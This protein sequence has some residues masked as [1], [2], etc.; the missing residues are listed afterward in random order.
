MQ[1]KSLTVYLGSGGKA[2][3]LY[4]DAAKTLGHYLA[5]NNYRTVYGG[6]SAGTMGILADAALEKNGDVLGV[7]PTNIRDKDFVHQALITANKMITVDNMWKRKK[8]L[9][10]EGDAAIALPG[11]YGTLDEIFEFLYWGLKGFHAKPLGLLNINGY[12]TPLLNFIETACEKG[13]LEKTALAYL[14]VDDKIE[15]LLEKLSSFVAPKI[16]EKIL[17]DKTTYISAI[18]ESN[19]TDTQNPIIVHATNIEE[20]YRLANAL[21]LKQLNK[22]TRPIGVL[23]KDRLFGKLKLWI[24]TAAVN[25]FITPYCPDLA[26]FS[27]DEELLE[28]MIRNHIHVSVDLHEKWEGLKS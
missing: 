6:M 21:V 22:V 12:W 20:L 9:I 14:F 4:K 10:D 11:G 16:E 19:L 5:D 8:I 7:I 27:E 25:G 26:V 2:P 3:K 15:P 13:A 1:I 23:D 28:M 18:E 17:S 24:Y